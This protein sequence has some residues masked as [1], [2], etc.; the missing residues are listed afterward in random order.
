MYLARTCPSN[1]YKSIDFSLPNN[2]RLYY[3]VSSSGKYNSCI[4]S[5]ARERCMI[6]YPTGELNR[7]RCVLGGFWELVERALNL[8]THLY[9]ILKFFERQIERSG[10]MF[11]VQANKTMWSLRWE[12]MIALSS[13]LAEVLYSC[14]CDACRSLYRRTHSSVTLYILLF[15]HDRFAR[16]GTVSFSFCS[17]EALDR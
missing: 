11:L 5:I 10:C 15:C 16:P 14:R 1:I 4:L 17:K 2:W 13:S 8:M 6:F 12:L 3:A 7:L 9:T